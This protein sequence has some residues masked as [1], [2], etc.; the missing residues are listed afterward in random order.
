MNRSDGFNTEENELWIL[1]NVSFLKSII[2]IFS[3]YLERLNRLEGMKRR[4]KNDF[5]IEVIIVNIDNTLQ[6]I[7][8]NLHSHP[9]RCME[10]TF[11]RYKISKEPYER[12]PLL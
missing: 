11:T 3:M 2:K 4:S 12:S 9:N 6:I 1:S 10:Q 5:K 8:K 7:I